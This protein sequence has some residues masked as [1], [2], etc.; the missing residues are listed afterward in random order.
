MDRAIRRVCMDLPDYLADF[1]DELAKLLGT[2]KSKLLIQILHPIYE[3][4]RAGK[5]A[6][7]R[8]EPAKAEYKQVK[9]Q[10]QLDS[11]NVVDEFRKVEGDKNI[12]LVNDFVQ[13]LQSRGIQLEEINEDIIDAFLRETRAGV[14]K[15]TYYVYRHVLKKFAHF[16]AAKLG[17]V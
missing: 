16:I 10:R 6:S 3:A 7:L 13:W 11:L 4:W 9:I 5:E 2:E 8:A 17:E 15:N 1:L 12:G 14:S